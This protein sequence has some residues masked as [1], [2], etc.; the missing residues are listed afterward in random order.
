MPK[1]NDLTKRI[2]SNPFVRNFSS[3]KIPQDRRE[4]KLSAP[5]KPVDQRL[6]PKVLEAV[7]SILVSVQWDRWRF[8]LPAKPL[9]KLDVAVVSHGHADHWHPNFRQKDIVLSPRE[10]AV[11][12][13]FRNQNNIIRVDSEETLGKVRFV[14]VGQRSLANLLRERVPPPHAFWW[15]VCV[16]N[17]RVI[18]VGDANVGDAVLLKRFSEKMF[19]RNLPLHCALL[20][21]FG[22]TVKHKSSNARELSASFQELANELRDL[23]GMMIGALP[24]PVNAD[25]ADYNAFRL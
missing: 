16:G 24:H 1:M 2:R 22:G 18:F 6:P 25:W 5:I 8:M 14:K 11:P 17:T 15:L 7:A 3:V 10:V 23:Y 9:L 12:E 21:S 19:E 4:V 13:Q 20:P